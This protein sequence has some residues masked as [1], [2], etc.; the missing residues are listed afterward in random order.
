MIWYTL[1]PNAIDLLGFIPSFLY[2]DD[3][4]PAREQIAERYIAGWQP[5]P[6]FT[7]SEDLNLFYEGDPPLD[8]IAYTKLHEE[9][10]LVYH[11]AWVAIVQPDATFEVARLD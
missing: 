6:G 4:R 8:P 1:S 7:F 11:Y 9:V 5:F 2:E 10:I 3:P